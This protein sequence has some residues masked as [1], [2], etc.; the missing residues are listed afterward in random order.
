MGQTG[1]QSVS[2]N[3]NLLEPNNNI[4]FFFHI[5]YSCFQVTKAELSTGH[6]NYMSRNSPQ[7]Y[8][9]ALYL[10]KKSLQPFIYII[11]ELLVT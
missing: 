7:V 1:P 5:G 6:K 4:F 2:V 9:L 8:S 10:K 3:I 11:Y